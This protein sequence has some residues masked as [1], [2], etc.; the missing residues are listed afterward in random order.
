MN[1]Q[2]FFKKKG[3]I[4]PR[5]GDF[6]TSN[7]FKAVIMSST[8]KSIDD[9]SGIGKSHGAGCEVE[10][11]CGLKTETKYL[12]KEFAML[13]GE[14][15]F[16]PLILKECGAGDLFCSCTKRQKAFLVLSPVKRFST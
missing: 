10:I 9:N 7:L 16:S 14:E 15:T 12:L 5:P 13:V 1:S 11:I 6:F 8:L 4:L 3:C 2:V